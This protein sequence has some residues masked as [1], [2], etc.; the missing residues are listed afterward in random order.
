MIGRVLG[1]E[2]SPADVA[3]FI[4]RLVFNTLMCDPLT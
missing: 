2:T 3:E 1:I 4:R